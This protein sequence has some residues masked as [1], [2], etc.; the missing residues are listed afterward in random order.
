MFQR[1]SVL[2]NDMQNFKSKIK[3]KKSKRY[4]SSEKSKSR[5]RKRDRS[6]KKRSKDRKKK[7]HI[8][9]RKT[10]QLT[11]VESINVINKKNKNKGDLSY[12]EEEFRV[13]N[14]VGINKYD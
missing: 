6:T 3:D 2:Q 8:I 14:Q 7:S 1:A 4:K 10:D 13:R 11:K 12:N 9:G 5:D